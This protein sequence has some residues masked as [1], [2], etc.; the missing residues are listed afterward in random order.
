MLSSGAHHSVRHGG[1]RRGSSRGRPQVSAR[2]TRGP[3][4]PEQASA[5]EEGSS[6]TCCDRMT[7]RTSRYVNRRATETAPPVQACEPNPLPN[8]MTRLDTST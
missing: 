4:C 6:D 2:A 5:S 1:Q 8:E 7:P 3:L